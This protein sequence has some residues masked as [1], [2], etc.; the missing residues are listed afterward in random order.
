MLYSKEEL[1][2]MWTKV[3]GID[4]DTLSDSELYAFVH[5]SREFR[6]KISNYYQK[7]TT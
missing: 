2:E 7:R 3:Q 5:T 6:N 1:M 4:L